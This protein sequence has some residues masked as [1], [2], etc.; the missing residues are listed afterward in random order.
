[1]NFMH[2]KKFSILANDF[3][4]YVGIYRIILES[5]IISYS[6]YIM[7][8]ASVKMLTQLNMYSSFCHFECL[9]KNVFLQMPKFVFS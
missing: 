2:A 8:L 6:Y 4:T 3:L 9:I 1:M 5:V 7:P